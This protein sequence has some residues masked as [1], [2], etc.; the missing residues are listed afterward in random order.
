MRKK[1][2]CNILQAATLFG[3]VNHAFAAGSIGSTDTC[4]SSGGLVNPLNTCSLL[5]IVQTITNLLF[6]IAAPLATIM[7]LY[8]GFQ[9]MTAGG[10]PEKFSN[11]RKTILYTAIGFLVVL[12]SNQI[13]PIIE[14]IFK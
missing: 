11:G 14:A 5:D 6:T 12:L 3:L 10:E 13:V 1:A 8:G 7:V 2:L 4:S 9:M